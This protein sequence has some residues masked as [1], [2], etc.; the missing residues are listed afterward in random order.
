MMAMQAATKSAQDMLDE[1]AITYNWV[2]QAAITREITEVTSKR[3]QGPKKE[4]GKNN[5]EEESSATVRN[6]L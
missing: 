5:R 6:R 2:R 3:S 1:P 4:E